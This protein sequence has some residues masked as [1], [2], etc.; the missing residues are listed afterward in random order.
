MCIIFKDY[1][2]LTSVRSAFKVILGKMLTQKQEPDPRD[3]RPFS[4]LQKTLAELKKKWRQNNDYPWICNQLKSIRQDL[5]V[6]AAHE[7][8]KR[9]LTHK[10]QVQRIKNE[11]TVQ[12]YEIHARMALE[13]V[14][15]FLPLKQIKWW[16]NIVQGGYG[17]ISSMSSNVKDSL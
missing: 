4:V 1:L 10:S 11:F 5:T 2:R 8:L 15:R 14:C 7:Q 6:S 12:V 16:L 17:R 3:I 13:A 9:E